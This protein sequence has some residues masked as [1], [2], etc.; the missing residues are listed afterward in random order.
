[1]QS[2]RQRSPRES[3]R[4]HPIDRR[5]AGQLDPQFCRHR[6]PRG[7]TLRFGSRMSMRLHRV[8][9]EPRGDIRPRQF[10]ESPD[11]T[12]AHA[13]Q[14]V[15]QIFSLWVAQTGFSGQL[16]DRQRGQKLRIATRR[17]QRRVPRGIHRRGHLIGDAHLAFGPGHRHRVG[18]PFRRGMLAAEIACGAGHRQ[19]QQSGTQ[20]LCPRH[21]IVHRRDHR[22]EE[23]RVA[24]GV[25]HR[26]MQLRTT[27][28]G[29]AP[30][31]TPPH[32]Q[33]PCRSG[34][35]RHPVGQSHRHGPSGGKIC[36][37]RSGHRRPVR[38]PHSQHPWRF[39]PF[40]SRL[41]RQI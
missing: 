5:I 4:I 13:P 11:G 20:N 41:F 30:P 27:R 34:A 14:Q 25:G 16:F 22:F 7:R 15:H 17:N 33:R 1:M 19:C 18:Q 36:H 8:I 38:T 9:I 10:R 31:H 35:C 37:R 39:A 29:L 12:N 23:P 26:D 40:F 6:M 3:R 2:H 32:S 24:V 28:L 21:Q